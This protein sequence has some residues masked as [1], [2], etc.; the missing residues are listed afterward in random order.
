MLCVMSP[1]SMTDGNMQRAFI[2]SL[3]TMAHRSHGNPFISVHSQTGRH[4][5]KCGIYERAYI[6]RK[7]APVVR[8][9]VLSSLVMEI[10]Q[11]CHS[12][13]PLLGLVTISTTNTF[14]SSAEKGAWY[15]DDNITGIFESFYQPKLKKKYNT[16]GR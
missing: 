4:R 7:A 14:L 5:C 6:R 16:F 2:Q 12:R 9:H 8:P 13:A 15:V 10:L 3:M 1:L 11:S